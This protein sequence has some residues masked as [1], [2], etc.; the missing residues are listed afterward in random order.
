VN[1]IVEIKNLNKSFGQLKALDQ[2][3]LTINPGRIVGLIGPNGSG[4]TT[5]LRALTGLI[6]YEGNISILGQ[7]PKSSRAEL[8]KKVGVIHDIPVIPPWMKVKQALEFQNEIQTKFN[9]D[10]CRERLSKT[11]IKIN[12][13]VRTL[14]KG[15]KTQLHLAMVLS[16]ETQFLVLDEPTHGLDILFRKQFYNSILEDYYNETR[17]V[18][19]STHQ[20]EE[21]E[22][23]LSDIIFI[24]KGKIILS[25][26]LENINNKYCSISVNE[27]NALEIRKLNPLYEQKILGSINFLLKDI[28][29]S[30]IEKYGQ[31]NTPSISDIFVAIMGEN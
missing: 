18:F 11:N 5:M 21:I 14:S 12:Q 29:K 10:K 31:I 25:D 28:E 20:V 19:I 15:M 16:T 24:R 2:I 4:K 3:N 6:E 8:M 22:H 17:S 26:S 27:K 9:I 30:T 13:K 7:E 1:P 23:I